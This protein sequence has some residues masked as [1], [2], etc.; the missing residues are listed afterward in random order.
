VPGEARAAKKPEKVFQTTSHI[1]IIP[2]YTPTDLS[3][4]DYEQELNEPGSF[5]FTRGGSISI[6]RM[7]RVFGEYKEVLV[8]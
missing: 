4:F 1:V 7:R 6:R 8:I 2:F 5:P 3:R